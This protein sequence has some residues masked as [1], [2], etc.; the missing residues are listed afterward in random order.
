MVVPVG[1][2]REALLSGLQSN[3]EYQLQV[4]AH[5]EEGAESIMCILVSTGK[6]GD[7]NGDENV[8]GTD[9]FG[10]ALVWYSNLPLDQSFPSQTTLSR[11]DLNGDERVDGRDLVLFLEVAR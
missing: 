9:L 11:L 3:R 8:D 10:Q 7:V 1:Q 5:T 2:P 6:A 4:S